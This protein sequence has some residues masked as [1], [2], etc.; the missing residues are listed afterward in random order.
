[1]DLIETRK[2]V[3]KLNAKAKHLQ[4]LRNRIL[5]EKDKLTS[6]YEILF[7]KQDWDNKIGKYFNV[8]GFE[9]ED[10]YCH[11]VSRTDA[12]VNV[13]YF[14]AEDK[15][16]SLMIVDDPNEDCGYRL[17]VELTEE[18]YKSYSMSSNLSYKSTYSPSADSK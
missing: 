4:Q 18:K 10:F 9:E 13:E 8:K 7:A 15:E 1:M 17:W 2:A 16:I 11:V 14:K 3:K 6:E 12:G 5:K